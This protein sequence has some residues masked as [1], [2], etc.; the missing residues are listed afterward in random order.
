MANG[1]KFRALTIVDVHSREA[2]AIAVGQRLKGENVIAALDSIRRH[3]GVPKLL[4]CDNGSEFSGR[5]LDQSGSAFRESSL[6]GN[7]A[8]RNFHRTPVQLTACRAG[9]RFAHGKE[10]GLSFRFAADTKRPARGGPD[11]GRRSL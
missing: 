6:A 5:L 7:R 4:F 8:R 2:L 10:G 1:R 11:L 3:R 9:D